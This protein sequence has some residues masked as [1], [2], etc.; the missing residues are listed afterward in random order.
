MRLKSIISPSFIGTFKS[1]RT[2]TRLPLTSSSLSVRNG[3]A[4][5]APLAD[6][7]HVFGDPVDPVAVHVH[8]SH[9]IARKVSVNGP[10]VKFYRDAVVVQRVIERVRLR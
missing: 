7:L 2:K 10:F 9:G 6:L 1:S 8:G 3:K 4:I 5:A